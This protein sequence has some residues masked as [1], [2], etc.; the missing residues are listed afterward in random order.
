MRLR[1]AELRFYVQ[2]RIA[3]PRRAVSETDKDKYIKCDDIGQTGREVDEAGV[4]ISLCFSATCA[5]KNTP[6]TDTARELPQ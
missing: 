2:Q 6:C 4:T 5:V 3:V 1:I